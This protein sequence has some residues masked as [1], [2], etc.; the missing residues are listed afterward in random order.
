MTFWNTPYSMKGRPASVFLQQQNAWS[1][2]EVRIFLDNH[3]IL[4]ALDN[5][6]RSQP[7]LGQ[8]IVSVFR[9]PDIADAYQGPNSIEKVTQS[10]PSIS[11]L[12]IFTASCML[13]SRERIL[14][15]GNH[16]QC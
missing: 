10:Q 2:C 3:G 14:G 9:N 16:S 13:H 8:L 15:K 7:V 1:L 11:A 6:P 5:F 12:V 4:D